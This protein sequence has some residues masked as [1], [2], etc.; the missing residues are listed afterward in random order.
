LAELLLGYDELARQPPQDGR[1][2][3]HR[4]LVR[5]WFRRWKGGVATVQEMTSRDRRRGPTNPLGEGLS[6]WVTGGSKQLPARYCDYCVKPGFF[7][8]Y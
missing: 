4:L 8:K 3:F 6:G 7:A 2:R 5:F 1:G